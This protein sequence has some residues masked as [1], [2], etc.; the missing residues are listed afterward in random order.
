M[1]LDQET[2]YLEQGYANVAVAPLEM[3]LR[4]IQTSRGRLEQLNRNNRRDAR[5][6]SIDLEDDRRMDEYL[7]Y[8]Q[9]LLD[10]GYTGDALQEEK[11]KGIENNVS[12][13]SDQRIIN[14]LNQA[15]QFR[16][17][18][19]KVKQDDLADKSVD[20][21]LRAVDLQSE[22]FAE[23]K[24]Q[25][26]AQIAQN[27]KK[28]D[29]AERNFLDLE[30][31]G[32]SEDNVNFG[33][34]LQSTIGAI[35]SPDQTK[36][37]LG[38]HDY[39]N[40]SDKPEL[41]A[42]ARSLRLVAQAIAVTDN[43][44][45]NG[46]ASLD[47][48][49]PMMGELNKLGIET[50]DLYDPDKIDDAIERI[51]NS[52]DK[53]DGIEASDYEDVKPLLI[54]AATFSASHKDGKTLQENLNSLLPSIRRDLDSL[55]PEKKEAAQDN[56]ASLKAKAEG[57]LS[58]ARSG[59]KTIAD[60]EDRRI[61]KNEED[62]RILAKENTESLIGGRERRIEISEKSSEL[63]EAARK[64]KTRENAFA[65]ADKLMKEG[66][67]D[68]IGLDNDTPVGEVVDALMKA[69]GADGSSSSS[70]RRSS[71]NGPVNDL[72]L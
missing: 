6:E 46:K 23:Q 55:D 49:L 17:H 4:D 21:Q 24:E 61:K 69:Y 28:L 14:S 34:N 16:G 64:I 5:E 52:M 31:Q 42:G 38:T 45:Q 22:Q 13:G 53:K 15:A 67:L 51:K 25:S 9:S 65:F 47:R 68:Q 3:Q 33:A 26:N 10:A 57:Q 44:T 29:L 71:G 8:S 66:R 54:A 70:P 32:Q 20:L 27:R 35:L 56:L 19:L 63:R 30:A 50:D 11:M 36:R 1:P 2:G 12:W 62:A 7:N 58:T 43:S 18:R 39:M 37:I 48:H 72:P 59:A 60:N 40:K 41:Q